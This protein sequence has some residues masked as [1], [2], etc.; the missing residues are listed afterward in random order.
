MIARGEIHAGMKVRSSDGKRLGRIVICNE[1]NFIVE[2]GLFSRVDY[3]AR[4]DDV[5]AVAGEEVSLSRRRSEIAS[6]RSD[7]LGGGEGA[8]YGDEG[9]GGRWTV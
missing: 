6:V 4:Y 1:G 8:T 5:A 2:K 9:G 7:V 3:L